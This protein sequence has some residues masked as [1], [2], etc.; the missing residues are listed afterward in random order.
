MKDVQDWET[1]AWKLELHTDSVI[2]TA[3]HIE[4]DSAQHDES[5]R[6]KESGSWLSQL[7]FGSETHS[8]SEDSG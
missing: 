7:L 6:Q 2:K 3:S 4:E 1:V 8:E 5:S